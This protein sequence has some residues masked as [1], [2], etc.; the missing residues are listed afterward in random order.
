MAKQEH[1]QR[2]SA[3]MRQD[4][5][6][7]AQPA[8]SY[9]YAR[10]GRLLYVRD[11]ADSSNGKSMSFSNV[12]GNSLGATLPEGYILIG[13]VECRV[14]V[15]L[16][17]TNNIDTEIGIWYYDGAAAGNVAGLGQYVTIYND[18][19][20][21]HVLNRPYYPRLFSE[22]NQDRLGYKTSDGIDAEVFYEN[23]SVERLYFTNRK[24]SIYTLNL[25]DIPDAKNPNTGYYPPSWS[26]HAFRER[27]EVV[28]P[29]VKL[30]GRGK[31]T[32]PSGCYQLSVQ[33]RSKSGQ[34][35][36]YQPITRRT[37]VTAEQ[38]DSFNPDGS[39]NQPYQEALRSNHHNR[40]MSASGKVTGESLRYQLKNID[41]RWDE[42]VVAVLYYET[43]G[44]PKS[45]Y[46]LKPQPITPGSGPVSITIEI[47][48]LDGV[49][50]SLAELNQRYD[51]PLSV[52]ALAAFKNRLIAANLTRQKPLSVDVSSVSFLPT[53]KSMRADV[54]T[55]PTFT[56]KPNLVSQRND[57]DPITNSQVL[58]GSVL[59]KS[60]TGQ[61]EVHDIVDDYL[62]DKGQVWEHLHGSY[63][64]G[65]T[66]EYAAV[67]LDRLGQ[68]MYATP[69]PAFTFPEQYSPGPN[70]ERDYYA[71][72]K[73]DEISGLYDLRM[74]GVSI[75]GLRLKK[76]D[77][78]D[79]E[80]RLTV[81]GMLIVRRPRSNKLLH[82][83]VVFP[84]CRTDYCDTNDNSDN[85]LF[86]LPYLNYFDVAY[87]LPNRH[88]YSLATPC[89]TPNDNNWQ[90]SFSQPHYLT[91]HSPDVLIEEGIKTL[92]STDLLKHV[93]VVGQA[94][95]QPVVSIY[96]NPFARHQYT[97]SYA[98]GTTYPRLTELT[99]AG[100][101]KPGD[102][103]RIALS[104]INNRGF[105]GTYNKEGDEGFDKDNLNLRFETGAHPEWEQPVPHLHLYADALV[106]RNCVVMKSS[107]WHIVD[108]AE[109]I[110][111]QANFR[112]VN[113]I[114]SVATGSDDA[115]TKSVLPYYS[116]GHYQPITIDVLDQLNLIRDE[117]G[118]VTHYEFNEVEV[119][120]GDAY[121]QH[122]DFTRM[123]PFHSDSCEQH[124]YSVSHIVPIET[125][126]N[127]LLRPGRTFAKNAVR[128]EFSVC[129]NGDPSSQFNNGI[130]TQQP[131]D[132]NYNKVLFVG[133]EVNSFGVQPV[134]Q[135]VVTEQPSG[136]SWTPVKRNG[137]LL[138]V[139]RMRLAGDYG[140]ADGSL[141]TITKLSK[142]EFQGLYCWQQHG[143]GIIPL[144]ALEMRAS[145]A[146]TILTQSGAVFHQMVYMSRQ[147]GTQH[148]DSVWKA[149][150]QL[151]A[152]DARMGV[153]LRHT[154][155]GLDE[156]SRSENLNDFTQVLT[157]PLSAGSES[158]LQAWSAQ[159]G[160]DIENGEI[161]LT[162]RKNGSAPF[163]LVYSTSLSQFTSFYDCLPTKYGNRGRTLFSASPN[164]GNLL[165]VHNRG[166]PGLWYGQYFPTRL[167]FIVN[168][169]A[170]RN[171][172]FDN[173]AI[174]VS[175]QG[176][177]KISKITH[178]TPN[179]GI[180]QNHVLTPLDDDR[181][182][183]YN[184][185]LEYPMHEWDWAG[186]K[187]R[188]RDKYLT[189]ELVITNDDSNTPVPITSFRTLFRLAE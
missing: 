83:G 93:G 115:T 172:T 99:K 11:P 58:R 62:H 17:S 156:L 111:R 121:V 12:L 56:A 81:S 87:R 107:E 114:Q 80:G 136:F 112:L 184:N 102:Q 146:G 130:M 60:F 185:S 69:L 131:E 139:W 24:S 174:N 27:S 167:R 147:Y 10:N 97:K 3:G 22:P 40:V 154:Q 160:V 34:R 158:A 175:R 142:S 140:E 51:S 128:P 120:G 143:F 73:K 171:K 44:Q 101:P 151:G 50:I 176:Y 163:T 186:V 31:G 48:Q 30:L 122:F 96:K 33:Y 85:K 20:D 32:L 157:L 152:W 13:S 35:S 84:V 137:Q 100:R 8:N 155:A 117:S 82:Q 74:M 189:V 67:L 145:D 5:D 75:S 26:V 90:L 21:P 179:G 144:D 43:E 124:D 45:V 91:Y 86:P 103:S 89:G 76:N 148:P 180:A 188:L 113:Y 37:F 79:A 63:W 134:D 162:F 15:V 95:S 116:T 125:K 106:E 123:Y 141:G 1:E 170:E 39:I 165:F 135:V 9:R 138:D 166:L 150:G 129:N 78:F 36:V 68:P 153:L 182:N 25:R 161:L 4:I 105:G 110:D 119:W 132:W 19:L 177:R 104:F 41:T 126:Y 47:K 18:R 127:L 169:G 14:G 38:M 2:F 42:L 72:T 66:Y 61:D 181:F 168:V 65:E 57:N 52:G 71:L 133:T 53:L 98:T 54:T 149:G 59:I 108:A 94:Y 118:A 16:F 23:E 64:R 77:L 159:S 178:Y 173:G 164:N 183:Y 88:Q 29:R 55:E 70:G 92:A 46:T 7:S 49:E 187:E 6:A 109:S 28:F